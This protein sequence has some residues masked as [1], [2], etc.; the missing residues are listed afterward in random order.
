M[1]RAGEAIKREYTRRCDIHDVILVRDD[2]D[3]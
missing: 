1:Y 2:R 3:S